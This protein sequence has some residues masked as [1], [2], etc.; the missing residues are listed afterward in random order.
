[1]KKGRPK[2]NAQ[3][4]D[5]FLG[6]PLSKIPKTKLP[7]LLLLLSLLFLLLLLRL[8]LLLLFT[9]TLTLFAFPLGLFTFWIWNVKITNLSKLDYIR[10]YLDLESYLARDSFIVKI[11]DLFLIT[12]IH[13]KSRVPYRTIFQRTNFRHLFEILAVLSA[14]NL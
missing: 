11:I 4:S 14:E 13:G 10:V 9:L 6:Y 8:F 7:L 3:V 5:S 12:D 2:P 1:M